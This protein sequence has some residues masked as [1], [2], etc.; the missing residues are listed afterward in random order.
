M[1]YKQAGVDIER[2]ENLTN[3]IK[4]KLKNSNIGKFA[5]IFEHP[6]FQ[7]KILAATTDGIGSKIIP[8]LERG[9]FKTIA[10]DL[11][12]ANLN[13]LACS[14]AQPLFFLDYIA[15][16]KLDE[17]K[18]AE[19]IQ[20]LQLEL[21]TY[22]CILL[23]GETSELQDIIKD[24]LLD[25]TGFAIGISDKSVVNKLVPVNKGDILVGL[26]SSGPHANGYTLIRKLFEQKLISKEL[27]VESL[28]PSYNYIK[29]VNRLFE[30]N[31]IRACANITGGGI[32]N[33]VNRVVSSGMKACIDRD[34]LPKVNFFEQLKNIIGEEEA[35]SVFNMG[36]G[37]VLVLERSNLSV[38]NDICSV[39]NPVIIGE[40]Q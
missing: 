29:E 33:N 6:A 17:V 1:D 14:A 40:I 37:M 18:I 27:F 39:Y 15:T 10:I 36:I 12:A 2:A 7:D 11:V 9:D 4:S 23:G 31:A 30:H 25:I 22:N 16:N 3:L 21:Q 19:F 38:V 34:L 24:K 20:C 28:N 8:L 35:Y 13:D 32:L 26:M 5:G